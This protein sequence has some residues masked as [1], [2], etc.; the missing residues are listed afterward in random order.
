VLRAGDGLLSRF[1][2]P[3]RGI[4]AVD[5]AVNYFR[6]AISRFVWVNNLPSRHG[7]HRSQCT[8]QKRHCSILFLSLDLQPLIVSVPPKSTTA[9]SAFVASSEFAYCIETGGLGMTDPGVVR[10]VARYLAGSELENY[11]AIHACR[12]RLRIRH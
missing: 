2:G 12:I 3:G 8:L 6:H 5:G 1:L 7:I 11:G 9:P 10:T 4:K